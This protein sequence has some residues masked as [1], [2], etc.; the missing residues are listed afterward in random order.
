VNFLITENQ[1]FILLN[2][3]PVFMMNQ[4]KRLFSI[5]V[6]LSMGLFIYGQGSTTSSM[7]GRITDGQGEPLA[8]ATIKATHEPSGTVYGATANNQGL[9]TIQGMRPGGPYKVEVSFIGFS[10]R[11]LLT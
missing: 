5:L 10:K 9:F 2:L 8:G 4:L 6:F 3:N 7:S 1:K 11:P